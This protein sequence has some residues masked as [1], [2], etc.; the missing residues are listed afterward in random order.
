MRRSWFGFSPSVLP[1]ALVIVVSS[2][3]QCLD[4]FRD[5]SHE[6]GWSLEITGGVSRAVV[7]LRWKNPCDVARRFRV[8]E[9]LE[10]YDFCR[11][12][13]PVLENLRRMTT[14]GSPH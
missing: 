11:A 3:N 7:F 10:H 12:Q 2:A 8:A 9:S 6:R 14:S 1:N 13:L 4:E 5:E